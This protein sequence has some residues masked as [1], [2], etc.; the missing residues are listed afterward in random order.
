MRDLKDQNMAKLETWTLR[1]R[2]PGV[3]EVPSEGLLEDL[4]AALQII[5]T[6]NIKTKPQG[7][8]PSLEKETRHQNQCS[9]DGI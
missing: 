2:L 9:L 6:A 8:V 1:G 4:N 5:P 7:E 3:C